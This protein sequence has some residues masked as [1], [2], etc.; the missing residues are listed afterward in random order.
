MLRLSDV[1]I[2]CEN[3]QEMDAFYRHTLGLVQNRILEPLDDG[4]TDKWVGLDTGN[5]SLIL[6]P[7]GGYDGITRPRDSASVHISFVMSSPRDVDV[8]HE[9]L[10]RAGVNIVVPPRDWPWGERAC[11]IRDPEG[12]LLEVYAP[13]SG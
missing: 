10:S 8:M 6:K 2:P 13:L 7:R 12:N 4:P 3:L 1:H 9:T 11:F 5:A